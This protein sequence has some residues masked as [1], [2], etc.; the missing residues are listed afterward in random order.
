MQKNIKFELGMNQKTIP[1]RG[2]HAKG[3]HQLKKDVAIFVLKQ[4]ILETGKEAFEMVERSLSEK[5]RCEL[6][7]CFESPEYLSD[8]L[9]YVYDG[10]HYKVIKSITQKLDKFVN[11]FEIKDFLKKLE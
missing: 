4:S 3:V 7:D 5:Y 11:D 6:A 2:T 1:L 8:V 10:S 9:K